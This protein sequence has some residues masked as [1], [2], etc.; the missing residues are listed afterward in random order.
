ML[1]DGYVFLDDTGER[2]SALTCSTR[3]AERSAVVGAAKHSF[4]GA[5]NAASVRRGQSERPLHVTAERAALEV[6]EAGLRS[7]HG[8]YADPDL[9]EARRSA[10]SRG[11]LE[12]RP[13][14]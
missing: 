6:A 2:G 4:F 1:V 10:V 9:A 7:M 8:E 3:S 12:R 11:A 5:V 13:R 14:G